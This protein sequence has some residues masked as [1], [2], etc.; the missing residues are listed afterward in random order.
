[1]IHE[2]TEEQKKLAEWVIKNYDKLKADRGTWENHW[3]EL[4]EYFAPANDQIT[5]KSTSGE[6][7]NTHLL[8]S[9]PQHTNELLASALHSMLT[10]PSV[11][12]FDM[13]TGD[14]EADKDEAAIAW[15]QDSVK[16]MVEVLNNS[17]FQTQI[18]E[19]YLDLGVPGTGF[20]E[21]EEDEEDVVRF[22]SEHINKALI[23]EDAKSRIRTVYKIYEFTAMQLMEKYGKD[24]FDEMFLLQLKNEPMKKYEVIHGVFPNNEFNPFKAAFSNKPYSSVHVLKCK[25]RLIKKG[26]FDEFPFA[27]PRW[28]KRSNEMHGRSPAMK[29]LPDAKMLNEV[30]RTSIIAAQKVIDPTLQAPDEGVVLPLKTA[31][32]AINYYRAGT[33]DRIEPLQTGSQPGLGMDFVDAIKMQI[34]EAFFIDQL[35]L[36][37]GPQMTATEVLQRTEEKLRMMGP[38]LG[39]LHNELLKPIVDRVFGIMKRRGLFDPNVPEILLDKDLQVRY[40]SMIARAQ[41]ATEADNLQRVLGVMAPLI[42]LDPNVMDNINTDETFRYIA[43]LFNLPQEIINS[44]RKIEK[45]RKA[46]AE[47]MQQQEDMVAEQHEADVASKLGAIG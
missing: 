18:H 10:N 43:N 38:I 23:S 40:S 32:G 8:D 28:S 36:N 27:V 39:R 11:I 6:K 44:K 12:W 29:A 1:M 31:P 14:P 26:G 45:D 42:Q 13:I 16:R 9:T 46:K 4:A 37:E 19:V 7:K 24:K 15:L 5:S 3:Q 30:K 41:R 34:R 21:M 22:K 33:K 17:N 35:Q 2:Q 25:K 20:L 47:M